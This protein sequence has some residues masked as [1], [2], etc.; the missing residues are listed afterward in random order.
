MISNESKTEGKA[1]FGSIAHGCGH[2]RVRY[3]NY[4]IGLGRRFAREL[5]TESITAEVHGA[6]EDEA[7]RAGEINV[8]ENAARL[9][10]GRSIKAGRD[11]LRPDD[12]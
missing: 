6:P 3:R 9:R 1:A 7:V 5:T 8:L 10:L 2:A 11:S 4:D 12:D